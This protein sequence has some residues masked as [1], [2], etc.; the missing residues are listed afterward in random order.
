MS[1]TKK[2][3][4]ASWVQLIAEWKESGLSRKR[5]CEGRSI[6]LGAFQYWRRKLV[7]SEK[8]TA[9]IA[10]VEVTPKTKSPVNGSS[11]RIVFSNGVGIDVGTVWD[12]EALIR[13]IRLVQSV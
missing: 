9:A 12:D 6:S 2:L 13:L 8:A 5:F 3:E 7:L 10:F 1:V 11:P 4:N